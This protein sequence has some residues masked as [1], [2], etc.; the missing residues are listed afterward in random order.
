MKTLNV[1][2]VLLALTLAGCTTFTVLND[3]SQWTIELASS[4][5]LPSGS[6]KIY[7]DLDR[8]MLEG[9]LS[10]GKMDGTWTSFSSQGDRLPLLKWSYRNGMRNGPVQMWYGPLAYPAASGHL[11]TEGTFLNGVYDG[12][13][14]AY[15]PSGAKRCVRVYDHGT[16]K[17]CQ[18]WSP[19]GIEYSTSEA[20]TEAN[21][22]TQSD[23]LYIAT[24]EDVVTRSLAQAHRKIQ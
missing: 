18:Y 8:L 16:L 15:Y 5:P 17:S 24:E 6:C 1:T 4:E 21:R 3:A 2:L 10:A 14:T 23:L 11:N 12:A 13:V 22:E 9:T 19:E 7:D 20:V